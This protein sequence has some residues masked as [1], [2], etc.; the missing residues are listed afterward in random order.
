MDYKTQL[1]EILQ[2]GNEKRVVYEIIGERGPDHDK[3]FIS[4]VKIDGKPAGKGKGKTKKEAEQMAAKETIKT[5]E[6][7]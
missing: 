7:K 1:Q 4:Q 3:V 2:K 5:L 6:N